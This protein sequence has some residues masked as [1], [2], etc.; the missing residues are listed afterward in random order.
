MKVNLNDI[1]MVHGKGIHYGKLQK[2]AEV[3]AKKGYIEFDG[4]N[5][6]TAFLNPKFK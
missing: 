4:F 6:I 5:I 3:L 1:A 2:A